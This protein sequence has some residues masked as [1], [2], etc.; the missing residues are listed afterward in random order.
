[1]RTTTRHFALLAPLAL[2]FLTTLAHAAIPTNPAREIHVTARKFEFQ[3][4]TITVRKGEA[5][6]LVITSE[7]VDHGFALQG[8]HIEETIKAKQTKVIEFT[9]DREGKFA[10]ACSVFCGDGHDEMTGELIVTGTEPP[11]GD[12]RVS[13]DE[14]NPG[15][16]YVEVNG[17][18][19]RIDTRTKTFA[20]VDAGAPAL[21]PQRNEPPVVAKTRESSKAYEPYDYHLVNLPTP[22][23]VPRH[24]LNFYF[25]HRFSEPVRPLEDS[26]RDLLGLDSFSVSSFGVTYGITDRL[27]A[28]VY[29]S[30]ICQP[31]LCKTIEL[32]LGY[33]LLS[34]AG[35]SPL[36]LSTYASVEGEENFSNRY[37]FNIQAMLARSV[38]RFVNLFF[39]PAVHINAN[40]SGRFN[41]RP[42]F[43]TAEEVEAF[44][45]GQH[46]GSFGFGVNGRIRP[47]VSL[48]FEYTP[49][50]GFKLGQVLPVFD[51]ETGRFIGFKNRSE[52]EIGFGIEKRIGRHVFS[53]TFSNTQATTTSRY[54]SS[55][56]ALPPS[57]FA[58]GFN[59][60]RRLF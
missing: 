20:R 29:R 32:G 40:G 5:V 37:T 18:R 48:L 38:T 41:P 23:Q 24:S 11:A 14:T 51:E 36:A 25:T 60:F 35:R 27:Y 52:A 9:P 31:G 49:R 28:N 6:R 44:R 33:H 54:N 8:Y 21:A 43:F 1:M 56:L 50:V 26:G 34:E 22:K 3:P 12:M 2:L 15:V 59:L 47:T 10:F 39:S 19:L 53:L 30:P 13:F 57:K 16:A 46:S 4:K 7:D 58:I 45:L 55:N 17:E 42:G